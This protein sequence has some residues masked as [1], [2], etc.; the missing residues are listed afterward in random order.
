MRSVSRFAALGLV[1]LSLLACG[2]RAVM[3]DAGAGGDVTTTTA[4]L[5]DTLCVYDPDCPMG[6]HCNTALSPPQ[7][8]TLYCGA[9]GTACGGSDGLCAV[10]LSCLSNQCATPAPLV[11]TWVGMTTSMGI[12]ET[13]TLTFAATTLTQS[14]TISGCTGSLAYSDLSWVAT[15]STIDISGPGQCTGPIECDGADALSCSTAPWRNT[16]SQ[17]FSVTAD[18]ATLTLA[19]T[20]FTRQD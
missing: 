11:G 3:P 19:G 7:C 4:C 15:A 13:E 17:P 5:S 20:T 14:L 12:V 1:A 16:G 10:G 6:S 8:Q 18:G 9:A 2:P